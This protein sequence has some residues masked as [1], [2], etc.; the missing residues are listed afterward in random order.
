MKKCIVAILG[1][2][3]VVCVPLTADKI[4][5]QK[6]EEQKLEELRLEQMRE[7]NRSEENRLERQREI[8]KDTKKIDADHLIRVLQYHLRPQR[9][10]EKINFG[11]AERLSDLCGKLHS[12][13][14][15]FS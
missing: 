11:F 1:M 10:C 7:D 5:D 8:I 4:E 2:S 3:I 13:N 12:Q 15:N 9:G 14:S 6:E